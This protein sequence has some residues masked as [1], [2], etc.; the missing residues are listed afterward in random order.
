MNLLVK[1]LRLPGLVLLAAVLTISCEDPGKIGLIVDQD[2]SA[3]STY[4][5]EVVLPSH[6]VQFNPRKTSESQNT[7]AGTYTSPDFGVVT[8]KSYAQLSPSLFIQPND[9]AVYTGFEMDLGFDGIEGELLES[10]Q[11]Q[12]VSIYQLAEPIDTTINY[13]RTD[14]LLLGTKL[15]DWEFTPMVDDTLRTDSTYTIPLDDVIGQD[16]FNQLQQGSPIFDSDAAFNAYFNGIA[17]TP[18]AVT[19]EIIHIYRPATRLIIHYDEFNTEGT[20]V[21]RTYTLSLGS[22]GFYH[23]TSDLSGTPLDGIT[24]DNTAFDPIDDYRYL[25][26]G[27]MMAIQVDLTP[28]YDITDTLDY[29]IV[30]KAEIVLDQPKTN[31]ANVEMPSLMYAYFTDSTYAWPVT[32]TSGRYDTTSIGSYIILLQDES[33]NIKPGV[34]GFPNKIEY[35]END[36]NFTINISLFFQNLYAGNFTDESL[37]FL[38]EKGQILIFGPTDVLSPQK[39]NSHTNTSSL[40]IPKDRIRLRLHYTLPNIN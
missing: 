6:V 20:A 32:D 26:F 10:Q 31:L 11:I 5:K 38:E 12:M 8:A 29:M 3:L 9:N 23:I 2:N 33:L 36:D 21:P 1:K 25:Q 37:P 14:E 7:Q 40:A 22:H 35:D 30:N 4:F 16:L 28:F 15:G 39:T 17:F 18:G 13:T 19:K 27:T 34:Y 24:A